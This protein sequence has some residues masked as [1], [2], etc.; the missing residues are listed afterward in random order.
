V[1]KVLGMALHQLRETL[2]ARLRNRATGGDL[3]GQKVWEEGGMT[4]TQ[5][6]Y[7]SA[8]E[9]GPITLPNGKVLRYE[10]VETEY[11]DDDFCW[12]CGGKTGGRGVPVRK[13]IKPTF[14]DV[15]L[16]KA[17]DSKAVCAGC[18]FCLS[19]RELRNYSIVAFPGGLKHPSRAEMR[20]I[21]LNPPEWPFVI[22]IAVSG[23]KWL[24]IR[25]Q[26]AYSQD[27]FPVQCEETTVYVQRGELA[28]ILRPV[29]ELYTGGFSKDEIRSGEYNPIHI[30]KFGVARFEELE[31]I[32]N[33]WRGRRIFELALFVAQK[34]EEKRGADI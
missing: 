10:D 28:Q 6:I 24:H 7:A 17:Q 19:Y 11:V 9:A 8:M 25:S 5:L 26:V 34:Q 22:C 30:N 33:G 29:E 2:A 31:E 12:L 15:S 23:Q 18:A 14:M 21:L 1:E 27:N 13:A 20:E 32:I 4:P 3:A 16:A